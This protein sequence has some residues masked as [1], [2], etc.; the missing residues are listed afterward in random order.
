MDRSFLV[1]LFYLSSYYFAY[2]TL[3]KANSF[4]P[5]FV[6][7]HLIFFSLSSN[8]KLKFIYDLLNFNFCESKFNKD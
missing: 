6:T 7:D 1:I 3:L 5:E 2:S 8:T 4:R